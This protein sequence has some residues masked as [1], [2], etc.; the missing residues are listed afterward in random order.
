MFFNGLGIPRG[1]A[2]KQ[3]F[4]I[5]VHASPAAYCYELGENHFAKYDL[6]KFHFAK[7]WHQEGQ[8]AMRFPN[9]QNAQMMRFQ[10]KNFG[11]RLYHTKF[12]S[13]FLRKF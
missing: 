3:V 10:L 12:P 4:I 5:P 7:S 8:L 9:L 2:A 11:I 13:P 1:N 6:Q